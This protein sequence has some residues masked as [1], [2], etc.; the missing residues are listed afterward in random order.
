MLIGRGWKSAITFGIDWIAPV[1]V[2]QPQLAESRKRTPRR[3]DDFGDHRWISTDNAERHCQV[4]VR[5]QVTDAGAEADAQNGRKR[6][7]GA[8]KT[9]IDGSIF[10]GDAGERDLGLT[11]ASISHNYVFARVIL[12]PQL[13]QKFSSGARRAPHA[14]Q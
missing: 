8:S 13:A 2:V 10:Q 5:V 14:A 3:R 1:D 12:A 6:L 11:S 9:H 4:L 7:R